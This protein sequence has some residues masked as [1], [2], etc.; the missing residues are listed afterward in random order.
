MGD[1]TGRESF[2]FDDEADEVS[3]PTLDAAYE[4][5]ARRGMGR[6]RRGRGARLEGAAVPGHEKRAKGKVEEGGGMTRG[7][8]IRGSG[9]GGECFRILSEELGRES[10]DGLVLAPSRAEGEASSLRRFREVLPMAFPREAGHDVAAV[11]VADGAQE[12]L[13]GFMEESV[14]PEVWVQRELP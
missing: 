3:L 7:L 4:F 1:L 12:A 14:A 2:A 13:D 6:G 5:R 9:T 10:G 11:L 8:G